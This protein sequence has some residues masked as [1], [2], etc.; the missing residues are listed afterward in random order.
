MCMELIVG[1]Y[2][3]PLEVMD[4]PTRRTIGMMGRKKLDG[5]MVFLF[6]NIK[7]QSFWMKNCL[8]PLDIIMLIDNKVTSIHKNCPPCTTQCERY[9]GLGNKVLELK[10]GMCDKLGINTGDVLDIR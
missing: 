8:I 10:G 9:T 5:G 2:N 7:E 6:P 1:K 4:T 3:L